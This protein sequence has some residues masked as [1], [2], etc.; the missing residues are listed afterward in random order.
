MDIDDI[1]QDVFDEFNQDCEEWENSCLNVCILFSN[2]S[3]C[4]MYNNNFL[5]NPSG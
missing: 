4:I 2:I 1:D 5:A 3:F